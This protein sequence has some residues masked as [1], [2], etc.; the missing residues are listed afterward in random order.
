MPPPDFVTSDARVAWVR[1][2]VALSL[3]IPTET[4]DEYFTESLERARS[5]G[6]AKE[7]ILTWLSDKHTAGS[8]LFFAATRKEFEKEIEEEIKKEKEI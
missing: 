1:Q 8:S 2:R 5:A 7:E 4:F 3:D 6:I